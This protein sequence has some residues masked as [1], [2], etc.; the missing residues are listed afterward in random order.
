MEWEDYIHFDTPLSR[1][2]KLSGPF[3]ACKMR[4]SLV[5][6]FI[7][8][9]GTPFFKKKCRNLI[10]GTELKLWAGWDG[11]ILSCP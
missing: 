9:N 2:D 4:S 8:N 6:K 7:F 11:T 5:F 1:S 10:G 3:L